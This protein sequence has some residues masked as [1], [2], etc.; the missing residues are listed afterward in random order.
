MSQFNDSKV[1]VSATAGLT[2]LLNI[3]I[4]VTEGFSQETISI[5][6]PIFAGITIFLCDW[7]IAMLGFQSAQAMRIRKSVQEQIESL[8]KHIR[9][10]KESGLSTDEL[11]AALQKAILAQAR[12]EEALRKDLS[13]PEN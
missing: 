1:V 8:H 7:T 4:P 3:F 6:S 12:Q 2:V 10:N 5:I 11:E 9:R 13:K